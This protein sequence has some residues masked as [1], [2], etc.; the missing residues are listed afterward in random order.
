VTTKRRRTNGR[1]AP[2]A[3][4][5]LILRA[6]DRLFSTQGYHRTTTREIAD[7]AGVGESMIR[8]F[9]TKAESFETVVVRPFTECVNIWAATWGSK[10]ATSSDAEMIT[11]AF[12]KGFYTV[13]ADHRDLLRTAPPAAPN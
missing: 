2:A 1:R 9:G 8:N 5:N 10:K 4:Q 6:A 3:V 12:A 13:I 11:R 7:E